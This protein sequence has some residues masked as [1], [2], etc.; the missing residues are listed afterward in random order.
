MARFLVDQQLPH[1]LAHHL[2]DLGHD[3]QHIK[4]YPDGPTMPD[5][6]VAEI[7]DREGRA[8]VTKDKDFRVSHL[9]ENRPARLVHVTCGNI[10][11]RDLLHLVERHRE[12]IALAAK[13]FDYFEITRLGV[14]VHDP[15]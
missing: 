11:T 14:V 15:T 8:V 3:A 6:T 5:H 12:D 9:L 4:E 1:A 7:A 2:T 10:A 13:R